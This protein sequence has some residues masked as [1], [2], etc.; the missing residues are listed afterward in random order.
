M[1]QEALGESEPFLLFQEQLSR[2]ARVN[3]PV[4]LVG[5][6]GTGKE[7]AASRLHFLSHRWKSPFMTLNCAAIPS[8]LMES[9]LFGHEAGA[10]TGAL[11]RRAGRFEAAHTG[12]LFLDEIAT[13][14]HVLQEK[15]LRVAEYHVFERVGSVEPVQVD[16]RLVCATNCD[17]PSLAERGKFKRD[18][19]DRLSFEVLTLPPL[20][21]RGEDILLLAAHFIRGMAG[22]LDMPQAP[23]LSDRAREQ[24]LHYPWPGNVRELKNVVERA[25]Y[26]CEG[27]NI[28]AFRFDPFASS[29]RPMDNPEGPQVQNAASVE[30]SAAGDTVNL[31]TPL[32]VQVRTL[33]KACVKKALRESR[34]NQRQAAALLGLTYHQF[35][36]LF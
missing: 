20:R 34:H 24:L 1:I 36:N 3:R 16:V 21:Y 25:T 18:L 28:E 13:M 11:R 2:V 19:L 17:L 31:E 6:R 5:E 14:D 7:L 10:F 32:A 8:G 35:R 30:E 27:K 29:Y 4:L 23:G 15:I 12:T 22:E 9:E 33:Q 26:Q